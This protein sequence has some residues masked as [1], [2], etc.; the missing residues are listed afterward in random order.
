MS[1]CVIQ[2]MSSLFM[3]LLNYLA[4]YKSKFSLPFFFRY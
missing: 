3:Y 2:F 1:S 4:Y